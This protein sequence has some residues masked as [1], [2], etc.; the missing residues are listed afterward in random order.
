MGTETRDE[1]LLQCCL[2]FVE[3]CL[4]FCLMRT[5]QL[6]QQLLFSTKRLVGGLQSLYNGC[7]S[8]Q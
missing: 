2:L 7:L 6:P 4:Y 8:F 5:A 1:Y 3:S